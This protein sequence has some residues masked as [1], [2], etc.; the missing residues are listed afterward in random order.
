MIPV[1]RAAKPTHF[2][3]DVRT[4]GRL[5]INRL[6][7]KKPAKGKLKKVAATESKIPASK[8]PPYWRRVIPDL[9]R[10]YGGRCAYS[11]LYIE[12]GTGT[13][14]VDHFV[15]KSRNWRL[16]YEWSNYRLSSLSVDAKKN[17][18]ENFVDPFEVKEGWFALELVGLQ[19]VAGPRAP[20][21][22]LKQI[23]ASLPALNLPLFIAQ[24][25]EYLDDY[26]EGHIDLHHVERRAPFLAAE[27]RR[28]GALNPGDA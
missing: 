25:S 8:F 5:A 15:P 19:V 28:Q 11:A 2:D 22:R 21:A 4:P 12:S 20:K 7:G 24:R 3:A 23:E 13:P 9:R 6:V 17:N 14:S 10:L 18:A 27:L 26:R 16:V 1:S